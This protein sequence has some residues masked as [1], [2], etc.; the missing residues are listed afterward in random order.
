MALTFIFIIVARFVFP[1]SVFRVMSGA[2]FQNPSISEES[3]DAD[4]K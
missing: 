2:C 4:E 3:D 1:P